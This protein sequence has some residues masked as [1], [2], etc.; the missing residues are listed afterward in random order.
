M[1][2]ALSKLEEPAAPA[3]LCE[4]GYVTPNREGETSQ[5]GGEAMVSEFAGAGYTKRR[6]HQERHAWIGD[7][8]A[9]INAMIYTAIDRKKMY[10]IPAAKAAIV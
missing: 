8:E 4:G 6:P 3:M 10:E 5:V 1:A 2:A 7:M 9:Q